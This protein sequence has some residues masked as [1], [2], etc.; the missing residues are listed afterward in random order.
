LPESQVVPD[1]HFTFAHGSV[2]GT[3]AQTDGELS[4]WL[5]CTQATF[6]THEQIPGQSAPPAAGSQLSFGSSTHLPP[7]GQG[8]PMN[9]PHETPSETHL[10]ESQ[11]VPDAHITVAQGSPG[12]G[13]HAQ[14]GQPLASTTFPYWQ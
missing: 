8:A 12:G 10:P 7:P 3:Q 5:P 14:V 9:P 1:A 11:W 6:C 13:L 4:N 2:D